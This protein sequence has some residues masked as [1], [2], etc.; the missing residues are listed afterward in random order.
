MTRKNGTCLMLATARFALISGLVI[1][2]QLNSQTVPFIEEAQFSNPTPASGDNFGNAVAVSGNTAVVGAPSNTGVGEV[3]VFV[4]DVG[5]GAWA[6]EATMKPTSSFFGADVAIHDETIVVGSYGAVFIYVRSGTTWTQQAKMVSPVPGDNFGQAVAIDGDTVVVG[7]PSDDNGSGSDQG[8]IYVLYRTGST[9]TQQSRLTASD[10]ADWDYFG[11]RVAISGDNA[12]VGRFVAT[13]AKPGAAY[14]YMRTGSS[15]AE[16]QVIGVPPPSTS[17][18]FGISV[19]ISGGGALVGD[20]F[21]TGTNQVIAAYAFAWNGASWVLDDTLIPAGLPAQ[22]QGNGTATSVAIDGQSAVVGA[23]WDNSSL[24]GLVFAF[25]AGETGWSQHSTFSG[26]NTA[27]NDAFG[28]RVA[29]DLDTV[30]AGA[31]RWQA[32]QGT[33]YAFRLLPIGSWTDLGSGLPGTAGT[34]VLT[35][36]GYLIDGSSASFALAQA[37]P[38]TVSPLVIGLSAINAPF[39]GGTLVPM[40]DF[41][42]P[43]FSDF[44]GNASIATTWPAGVPA[45]FSTYFQWWVQDAAASAGYAA[46]NGL[47]ATTP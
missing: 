27:G 17:N 8:A 24:K 20:S 5:S 15:W 25:T 1:A 34:P 45:G 2:G 16:Q 23:P 46:S 33:A 32:S 10:A 40:P 44:N 30:I 14:V 6:L 13:G 12:I 4:R 42:L 29:I 43:L 39:K 37:K 41:I 38:L 3:S 26:N 19:A 47:A 28:S 11:S 21:A 35:G 22:Y 7:A 18:L 36:S 31:W 9:W